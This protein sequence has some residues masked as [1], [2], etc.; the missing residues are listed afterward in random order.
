MDV[1]NACISLNWSLKNP[2]VEIGNVGRQQVT[3]R[4]HTNY[5]I[6]KQEAIQK[7]IQ[8]CD[9]S[10][11]SVVHSDI[12]SVVT[13]STLS[14]ELMRTAIQTYF[15][16]EAVLEYTQKCDEQDIIE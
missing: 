3:K 16:N 6:N 14:F 11:M 2:L 7:N 1:G 12:Q 15:N 5:K 9:I 4:Q 13:L 8:A 10:P